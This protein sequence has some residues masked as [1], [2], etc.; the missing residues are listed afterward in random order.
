MTEEADWEYYYL[1]DSDAKYYMTGLFQLTKSN[2]SED[3]P[4]THT[5]SLGS[6]NIDF[7]GNEI[8]GIE[9]FQDADKMIDPSVRAGE[10][11]EPESVEMKSLSDQEKDFIR[12]LRE[13]RESKAREK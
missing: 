8:V 3:K 11:T 4:I 12:E 1:D 10:I 9:I 7:R 2:V 5:V 6:I 13:S